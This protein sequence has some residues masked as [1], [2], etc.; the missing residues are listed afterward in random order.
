MSNK[1]TIFYRGKQEISADFSAEQISSDGAVL[2]LEKL[3][4][5]HRLIE[6]YSDFIPDHR[7]IFRIIHPMYKLLKQRVFM[8]V[9]GYEDC[10]DVDHLK[11]DP[12][13]QDI[14]RGDMASQPTLSR[15]E[16]SLNKSSIFALCYAWIDKY[17][18]SLAGRDEVIIDIDC[19]DDPTHGRQ[20]LSLFNGFYG[21]FMY[22]ELFFH[23]GQTGQIILP[24][25]RPG[26]S[27]SNKWYV[28]ILKRI[29]VRI[30][31]V[32]PAM[33]ITIRADSGY[34]SPQF[35]KLADR[36]DL[37][38]AIGQSSNDVLKRKTSRA[39][40]AVEHLYAKQSEKHQHF[41]TTTYQAGSWHKAQKCVTK[42]ESTG[43]GM[44]VRHIITN[45]EGDP[46]AIYFGFYVKRGETSENRIMEVK[47]M[48]F[49]DRLSTHGFWSNFFRLLVSSLAY[50][51]M[52]LIKK[53]IKATKFEKAKVWQVNTIRT[54]LLKVGAMIKI[55][56]RR[57]YYRFS[58]AFVYQDLL[59]D[60]LRQN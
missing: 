9:Q 2:L 51:F 41:I 4:R 8:C 54:R 23:D 27:H 36:Y 18:S 6:Y 40:K 19:T 16:N 38:Y 42:V 33:K 37:Y 5:K 28:S 12:V 60:L 32:Y 50:E 56:K 20:Q 10:N 26:N 25:L 1:N 30:R 59:G 58:K 3:E 35:Y 15:L 43:K 46:R 53:A 22:N 34:S 57:I 17:V 24:I 39:R 11:N 14:L 47:N 13:F 7:D 45:I 29:I 21:Q 55:T 31:A 49:S 52:L 48:C 44:N